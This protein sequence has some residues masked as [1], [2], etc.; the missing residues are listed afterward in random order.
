MSPYSNWMG[1]ISG[2]P[3]GQPGFGDDPNKD[4][5]PNGLAWILLGTSPM[6]DSRAA[7]PLAS[8]NSGTLTL[9]FTCLKP[10]ELGTATLA[11]QYGNT[12]GFTQ[13]AAVPGS[14]STVSNVI[15]TITE[16]DETHNHVK[17]DIPKSAAAGGKHFGRLAASGN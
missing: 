3:S 1:N 16:A 8:N 11:V 13:S 7:L 9:E 12:L 6:G 15:F 10:G 17:A 2:V 14:S 5:V 4:G